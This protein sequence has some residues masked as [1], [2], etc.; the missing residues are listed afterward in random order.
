M[1]NVRD[2]IHWYRWRSMKRRCFDP[3]HPRFDA[4]GGRGI[5]V[6]AEWLDFWTF[7]NDIGYPP[8]DGQRWTL[9]RIDNDG[10]YEPGNVRWATDSEQNRNKRPVLKCAKGH[11]DWLTAAGRRYCR[12]CR[13][14]RRAAKRQA[15]SA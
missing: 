14:A 2:H 9:D 12:T 13:N 3:T 4:Y 11:D 6:C 7:V 8:D 10:N 15:V 1:A 5:T